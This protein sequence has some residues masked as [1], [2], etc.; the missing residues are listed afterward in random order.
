MRRG[1]QIGVPC[2][3]DIMSP[4][5]TLSPYSFSAAERDLI[6]REF[7]PRFGQ[8]PA[9]AHGLFLR[10]WRSGP[11]TGQPKIPVAMRGLL[12]RGLLEIHAAGAH[13]RAFFTTAGLEAL[14]HLAAHP[15]WLDPVRF[16][17]LRI[18]L[19]LETAEPYRS[20][21]PALA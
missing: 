20:P 1:R 18:E 13:P 11:Q 21:L 16:R 15:R 10:R 4:S 9:L 19:G 14:R 7:G 3:K 2:A 17:H 12:D 6:R 8:Q 5:P